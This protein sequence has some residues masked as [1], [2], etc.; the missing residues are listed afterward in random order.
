[1][2]N[3]ES[4]LLGISG[5]SNDMRNLVELADKGNIQARLAI[6]I[7][8]YRIRKYIGAYTAALG[9]LDA[10]VFTGGIGENNPPI[11]TAACDGMEQIGIELDSQKNSVREPEERL[12]SSGTSR[13]KVFVIP[14]DEERAI[15]G[16]TFEIAQQRK[17]G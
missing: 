16:D 13:V 8:C 6:D 3:K 2:C 17:K 7:F 15:A 11:R 9:R 14:A 10:V 4:G 1:M 5:V 12:I